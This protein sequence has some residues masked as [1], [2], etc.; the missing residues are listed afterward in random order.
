MVDASN[1]RQIHKIKALRRR[2][3]PLREGEESVNNGDGGCQIR[4]SRVQN[5]SCASERGCSGGTKIV[6][7][8]QVDQEP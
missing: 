5:T 8:V 4:M 7:S 2:L 1:T 3:S 6:Q